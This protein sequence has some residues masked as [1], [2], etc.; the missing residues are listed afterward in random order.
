[1]ATVNFYLDKADKNGQSFIL[2]TY[3]ANGQKFRHSVKVKISP[4]MWLKSKQRLK[5]KQQDHEYLNAHLNAL[6]EIITKAERECLLNYSTLNFNFIKQRF[7]DS[8]NKTNERKT[9][10][11]YF[12]EYIDSSKGKITDGTIRHYITCLNHLNKFSKKK[13]YELTFDRINS[14][15]HDSFVSFLTEDCKLLN[16]TIGNY[17]KII[18]S[19]MNF[20]FDNGYNKSSQDYK[21]FKVFREDGELIYLSEAEL[22]KIYDLE[23]TSTKLRVVRD[24]F[25]F[26][27]FTGL[28]YSDITKLQQENIKDEYIEI[29]TEKTRDFL[30]IPLNDFAKELLYKN[31][32]LLPKLFSNQKTNAYLKEIAKLAEIEEKILIIKY[33]GVDKVEFSEPK[34]NFITTHTARRTFVTLSLE[35]G[36]RPETVM[37]ITGHKDY[38]TFKKYIKLTDKVKMLEMNNIWSRKLRIA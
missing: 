32:G 22:L 15:F 17:I 27:C 26:A 30:R 34:Y 12:Q 3:L 1:M 19:F 10:A 21:K 33:R 11:L 29:K 16:N 37:S 28:R 13:R 25:C 38:K 20:A 35:K 14:T 18:K 31:G 5:V 6:E 36:M 7:N 2:M 8:L 9:L 24:N 23:L 4:T